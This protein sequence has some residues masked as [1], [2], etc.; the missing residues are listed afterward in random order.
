MQVTGLAVTNRLVADSVFLFGEGQS[1]EGCRAQ[2]V[3]G[4]V[5]RI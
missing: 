3:V 5:S 4:A 2:V 1:N